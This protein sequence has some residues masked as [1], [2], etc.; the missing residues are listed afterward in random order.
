MLNG[1]YLRL[2][3]VLTTQSLSNFYFCPKDKIKIVSKGKGNTVN[4]ISQFA[5]N[6]MMLV[7]MLG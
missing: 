5:Q 3:T 1:G 6:W 4:C 2:K 7:E